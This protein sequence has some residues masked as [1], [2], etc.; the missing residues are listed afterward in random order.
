M[1]DSL[2]TDSV[3]KAR[4][5]FKSSSGR[6]VYGGGAITPD[7]IV[8]LDTISTAEQAVA[9]A[10]A[11]NFQKFYSAVSSFAQE[12]KGKVRSDFTVVPAWREEIFKRMVADTVKMEKSVYDA[13]ASW[14]DRYIENRV[15]R[16]AFGDS[17]ARRLQLKDDTQLQRAI[18][19]LRKS[20]TQAQV[21]TAAAAVPAAKPGLAR[22][23]R[24][25]Q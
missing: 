11:P 16:I 1:T 15:A 21:F 8:P 9:R 22:S 13:G 14:V 18:E 5:K 4:P 10:I 24:G 20:T 7:L 23:S 17:T 6:V 3:R 19:V 2:E 25:Q 12:Q